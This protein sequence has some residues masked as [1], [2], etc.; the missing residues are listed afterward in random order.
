[1]EVARVLR[2]GGSAC[3]SVP[4]ADPEHEQPFDFFR[5]TSFS[6]RDMAK[7]SGMEVRVLRNKGGYFRRLSAEIRDLP[8]IVFPQDRP[9]R[10]RFLVEPLRALLVILF[11]FVGATALLA[12]DG[13]DKKQT[14]TTGYFCV[15]E[16]P[17][18]RAEA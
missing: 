8:F 13:L 16:K 12:L 6:L 4:Q 15:F 11:T 5:F 3:F 2:P 17:R 14:Y 7:A 9:Y 18:E 10:A 1:M